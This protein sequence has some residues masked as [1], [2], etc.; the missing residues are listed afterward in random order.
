MEQKYY[1]FNFTGNYH[2]KNGVH[3]IKVIDV[4]EDGVETAY[5]AGQSVPSHG[6]E[7]PASEMKFPIEMWL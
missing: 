1:K 4:D 7:I 5:C 3:E 6:S 2:V